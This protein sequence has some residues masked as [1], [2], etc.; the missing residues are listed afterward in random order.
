MLRDEDDVEDQADLRKAYF[1]GVAC[2]S[3]PIGL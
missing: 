1:D 3:A 2:D